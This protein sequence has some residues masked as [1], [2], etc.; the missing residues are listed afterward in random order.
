MTLVL[1]LIAFQS[2]TNAE[3]NKQVGS[4]LWSGIV[5]YCSGLIP[6]LLLQ[7]ILRQPLPGH[8]RLASVPAWAWFS[9]LISIVPTLVGLM[10]AQR[11]GPASL[12]G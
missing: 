12:Q 8:G 9:R 11:L 3:L 1:V 10:L 5:V 7:A 6:L 4:P 2:G